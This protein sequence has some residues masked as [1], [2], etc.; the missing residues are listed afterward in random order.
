FWIH[1]EKN[2]HPKVLF[3]TKFSDA[4]FCFKVKL[5]FWVNLNLFLYEHGHLSYKKLKNLL[6]L[7][8][9]NP[10]DFGIQASNQLPS[11]EEID[12]LLNEEDGE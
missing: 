11:E 5:Y 3:C 12:R 7:V 10:A 1:R 8:H 2:R 6:S 9:K 4:C